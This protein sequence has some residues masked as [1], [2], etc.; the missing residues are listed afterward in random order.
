MKKVFFLVMVTVLTGISIPVQAQDGAAEFHL[1]FF[2]VGLGMHMPFA[3]EGSLDLMKIGIEHKATGLGAGFSPVHLFGWIGGG[4]PRR[5]NGDIWYD[6][7]D[8]EGT[9]ISVNFDGGLS[10]LNLTL[11]WNVI[12]VFAPG[13]NFYVAPFAEL[14]Y[15][16]IRD[17]FYPDYMLSAGLSAGTRRGDRIKYNSFSIE[18]GFRTIGY[19]RGYPASHP[20]RFFIAVKWGR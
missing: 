2:N 9:P 15:M 10:V 3:A 19:L 18:T 17:E 4:E 16:I 13:E 20:N 8:E 12:S 5:P 1:T 6:T 7:D 11:F 14:N